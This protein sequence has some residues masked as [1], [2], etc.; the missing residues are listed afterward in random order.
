MFNNLQ[1][2]LP[3]QKWTIHESLH[4]DYRILSL[5]LLKSQFNYCTVHCERSRAGIGEQVG[6]WA[7]VASLGAALLNRAGGGCGR[8]PTE[9]QVADEALRLTVTLFS[10][11]C[12]LWKRCYVRWLCYYLPVTCYQ[13]GCSCSTFAKIKNLPEFVVDN[14]TDRK[15]SAIWG[16]DFDSYPA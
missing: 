13:Q 6:A 8:A 3:V 11:R 4:I 9:A 10:D 12:E 15:L 1:V 14:L 16:W 5:T 7:I 2:T